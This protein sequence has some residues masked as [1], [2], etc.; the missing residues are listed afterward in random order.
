MRAI[1][2]IAKK[3]KKKNLRQVADVLNCGRGSD[4]DDLRVLRI[5]AEFA[6]EDPVRV[7]DAHKR[8][9]VDRPRQ[10][11]RRPLVGLACV[12]VDLKSSTDATPTLKYE[13]KESKV[14]TEIRRARQTNS[15]KAYFEHIVRSIR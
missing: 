4:A 5:T 10:S 13:E 6:A 14:E 1:K 3:K 11:P 9:V 12:E 2:S 15:R 7:A 8:M